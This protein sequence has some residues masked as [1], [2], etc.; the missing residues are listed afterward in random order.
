[1]ADALTNPLKRYATIHL[2]LLSKTPPPPPS[3]PQQPSSLV[4]PAAEMELDQRR[5]EGG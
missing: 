3:H 2:T 5:K 1:M 4:S